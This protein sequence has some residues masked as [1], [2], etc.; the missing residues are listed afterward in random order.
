MPSLELESIGGSYIVCICKQCSALTFAFQYNHLSTFEA[1][2]LSC[3]SVYPYLSIFVYLFI[4]IYTYLSIHP[5]KRK[6]GNNAANHVARRPHICMFIC[7]FIRHAHECNH[8][9]HFQW[10]RH[11]HVSCSEAKDKLRKR[12]ACT[13]LELPAER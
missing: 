2:Y 3:L 8:C 5:N 6:A 10:M 13:T 9:N 11:L 12:I 1:S 7:K 4:S